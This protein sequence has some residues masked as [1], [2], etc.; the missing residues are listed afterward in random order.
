MTVVV[1]DTSPLRALNH[2]GLLHLLPQLY[3]RILIPN[4]V[5][6]EVESPPRTFVP[7]AVSMHPFLEIRSPTNGSLVATLMN[8]LDEGESAAIVLALETPDAG[9]LID[10][11]EGRRIAESHGLKAFGTIRVL[12][13]AKRIE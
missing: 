2:L 5:V 9:L 10:E 3:G 13:D 1:S 8:D 12:L 11:A 6:R 4:A 7:I